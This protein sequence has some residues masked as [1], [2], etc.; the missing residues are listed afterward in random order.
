MGE[1]KPSGTLIGW[2]Q[3]PFTYPNTSFD[4]QELLDDATIPSEYNYGTAASSS[5]SSL[6]RQHVSEGRR[7][8]R[9]LYHNGIDFL[10]GM[11]FRETFDLLLKVDPP[12]MEQID[13]TAAVSIA[14]HSRH[15]VAEDDGSHL[16]A[17]IKCLNKMLSKRQ[18]KQA[19]Q[20]F[21]M[22]DRP[23]TVHLL[24]LWLRK[25]NCTVLTNPHN[26]QTKRE[27]EFGE[28][29]PAAGGGFFL[30]LQLASHAR[31]GLV[32]DARIGRYA[33]RSSTTLLLEVMEYDRYM[34][35][36]S[37]LAVHK[38]PGAGAGTGQAI[39]LPKLQRCNLPNKPVQG[40][41]YGNTATFQHPRYDK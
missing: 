29:G 26:K 24:G 41:S 21:L 7:R 40:Y 35:Q 23:K 3:G 25:R 37:L 5:S 14:L 15:T 31:S 13:P 9:D 12:L 18:Q 34:E 30:D 10:Y 33:G 39:T 4:Y 11:L 8:A 36:A 2:S 32:G 1:D 28:H 38:K 6:M 17:E 22:S 16:E 19:C 20:V 27:D